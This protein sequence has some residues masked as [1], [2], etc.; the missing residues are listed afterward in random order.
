MLFHFSNSGLHYLQAYWS[1]S[2][3]IYSEE[4]KRATKQMCQVSLKYN[5]PNGLGND[6]KIA[7]FPGFFFEK[8][9]FLKF[10]TNF[11]ESIMDEI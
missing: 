4:H 10:N 7:R 2:L 11:L 1:K 9:H 3:W 5:E 6:L 8:C